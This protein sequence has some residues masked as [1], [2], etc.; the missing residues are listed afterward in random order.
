[1]ILLTAAGP[2]PLPCMHPIWLTRGPGGL[3][4]YPLIFA[5]R[6]RLVQWLAQHHTASSGGTAAG[7]APVPLQSPYPSPPHPGASPVTH[8]YFCVV[9]SSAPPW[10]WVSGALVY[11]IH[12]NADNSTW[13]EW[14]SQYRCMLR[15]RVEP[16]LFSSLS[17][18]PEYHS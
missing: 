13:V 6:L 5:L 17:F 18:L 10:G 8:P 12:R 9:F 1:M 2:N 3:R 7:M 4:C 16:G 11:S 14:L 15:I